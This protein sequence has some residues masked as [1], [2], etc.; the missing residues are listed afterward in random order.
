MFNAAVPTRI[1]LTLSEWDMQ[2]HH[3]CTT[4]QDALCGFLKRIILCITAFKSSVMHKYSGRITM[5][6][7]LDVAVLSE[8]A[9]RVCPRDLHS[10]FQFWWHG[11]CAAGTYIIIHILYPAVRYCH[12]NYFILGHIFHS[13][14]RY[15][16]ELAPGP[17][18]ISFLG[19]YI[20]ICKW[21][22]FASKE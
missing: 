13:F 6:N 10:S 21:P 20:L 17:L 22:G 19:T 2:Y 16:C 12:G 11:S 15:L 7:L 3:S 18:R 5:Q 9:L 4:F 8:V 1:C 14:V